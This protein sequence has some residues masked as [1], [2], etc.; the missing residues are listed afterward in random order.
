MKGLVLLAIAPLAAWAQTV[1]KPTGCELVI[2]DFSNAD[3]FSSN[4]NAL[5][6]TSREANPMI[7]TEQDDDHVVFTPG[8]REPFRC[9]MRVC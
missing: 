6:L 2:N 7:S 3:A 8:R 5:G 4:V 1:V 9:S